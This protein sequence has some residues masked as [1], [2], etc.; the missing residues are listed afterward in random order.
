MSRSVVVIGDSIVR[1]TEWQFYGCLPDFKMVC[2]LPGATAKDIS[3]QAE[4]F[5]KGE[6]EQAV[7]VV[8]IG[9]DIGRERDDVLLHEY[10]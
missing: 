2:C 5:L 1:S 3:E 4:D 6:G 10:R 9:T 7:V 8:H